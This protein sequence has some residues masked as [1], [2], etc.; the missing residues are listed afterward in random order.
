VAAKKLLKL[1]PVFVLLTGYAAAAQSDPW[2]QLNLS[3]TDIA[4]AT[5]H[6]EKCFEPNLPF[7][8]RTCRKFLKAAESEKTE[9]L[10]NKDQ[11]IAEINRILGVSEPPTKMQYEILEYYLG[12]SDR[13][14]LSFYLVTT[15]TVK[16]FLRAGG[17]LPNFAYNPRTDE[18]FYHL[19]LSAAEPMKDVQVPILLNPDSTFAREL[20]QQLGTIQH[21]MHASTNIGVAIHEVVEWTLLQRVKPDDPHC[22]WFTDGFA[23]AITIEILKKHVGSRAA[24]EFG[25]SHNLE[26]YEEL[27][28]QTNLRYWLTAN[29]CIEAP[30]EYEQKLTQARY[31]CATREAQK[32]IDEH[33]IGC[34]SKIL[35]N[36]AAKESASSEDLMEAIKTLTGQEM[37]ERFT[38]YQ[39]FGSLKEGIAGYYRAINAASEQKDAERILINLLRLMELNE[40]QFSLENLENRRT[41]ALLLFRLG[42]EKEADAVMQQ[43]LDLCRASSATGLYDAALEMSVLHALE[44]ER[45]HNALPAARELLKKDPNNVP[46]LSATML[47]RAR[48]DELPEAKEIAKRIR[49]IVKNKKSLPYMLA[50]DILAADPNKHPSL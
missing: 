45:P 13:V 2:Q 26:M 23:N 39:T 4:G 11:I 38:L 30:L 28:K 29:L 7:F 41:A 32:L 22:R 35:D 49:G 34:V 12:L 10:Q 33:G 36:V 42:H 14:S 9:P 18:A 46:A 8:E 20:N 43:N 21:V 19:G 44:T 37:Q 1:V 47:A 16:D 15:A 48:S 25:A 3:S 5:V 40:N 24:Q 50:S 27:K 17:R 31:A 6:Y